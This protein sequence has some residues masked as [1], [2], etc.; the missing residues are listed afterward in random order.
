MLTTALRYQSARSSIPTGDSRAPSRLIGPTAGAAVK[1]AVMVEEDRRPQRVVFG[2]KSIQRRGV[3]QPAVGIASA[4]A[5][6]RQDVERPLGGACQEHDAEGGPLSA[7]ARTFPDSQHVVLIR[8]VREQLDA[9][10]R[11]GD[12]VE[13]LRSPVKLQENVERPSA[14]G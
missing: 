11:R 4:F 1:T 3:A 10:V 6:K 9:D 14:G 8:F 5:G 2:K 12:A 13:R 7:L